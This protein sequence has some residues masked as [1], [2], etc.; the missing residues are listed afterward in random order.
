MVINIASMVR[1][2][3]RNKIP[4]SGI[5]HSIQSGV[6]V[7]AGEVDCVGGVGWSDGG[8][9]VV[10]ALTALQGLLVSELIALTF[11]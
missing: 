4:P 6:A 10:K 5:S 7:V 2:K 11:Q 8:G 9:S 3:A 1:R